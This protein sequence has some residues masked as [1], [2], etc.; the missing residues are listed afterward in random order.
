MDQRLKRPANETPPDD[1]AAYWHMRKQSGSMDDDERAALTQWLSSSPENA[2]AF[3]VLERMLEAADCHAQTLLASE[4][5]RDLT[6]QS[7]RGVIKR[8][9]PFMKIA[10]TLAAA[11]IAAVIA[12][13]AGQYRA[14]DVIAYETAKGS[15]QTV[16]LE[17]GSAA[18]LNTDTRIMVDYEKSRRAVTLL[19]GEAFFNVEKD[20]SRPFLVKSD[21]A[22]VVVTGTSF[23][24]SDL[25][26]KLIVRVLTGVVDV[27]PREG[28]ASTLLAGDMIEVGEDGRAGPIARYDPSMALAWRSGKARFHDQPLGEVLDTLNRYFETPIELGDRSLASLPVTGEF[29]IR[30]RDTAV[31]ALALIFNLESEEEPAR[32]VLKPAEIK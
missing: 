25:K 23:S 18:E 4:F 20:K 32:I 19:S 28:P 9:G 21:Q 13:F 7:E 15:H 16:T 29:D 22:E 14:P 17:D 10:A 30:D 26:G 3:A 6:I 5:E 31:T 11:L 1:A 2:R 12:I 8:S 27:T 24:V